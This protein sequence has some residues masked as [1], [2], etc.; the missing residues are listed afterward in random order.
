MGYV[1]VATLIGSGRVNGWFLIG[2]VS[3]LFATTRYGQLLLVKDV[4]FA[5]MLALAISN[6]FWIVP[7]LIRAPA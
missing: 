4:L 2:N 6:R 3:G 5:G 7:S 1:A